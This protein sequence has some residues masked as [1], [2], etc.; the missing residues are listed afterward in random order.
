MAKITGLRDVQQRLARLPKAAKAAVG[1][2]LDKSADELVTAQRSLAPVADGT[3][4]TSIKWHESGELQ[5]TVEA[6][7][8]ATTLPVRNGASATFDYALA[9]EFGTEKMPAHPFFW[10]GYR[11]LRKRIRSRIKRAITKAVKEEFG[12]GE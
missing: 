2:V 5:R 10:P 3:L 6:G 11:L 12:S 1:P 9:Q 8:Q 4:K 7:G